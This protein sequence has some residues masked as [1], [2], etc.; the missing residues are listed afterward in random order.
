MSLQTLTRPVDVPTHRRRGSTVWL[1]AL[2]SLAVAIVIVAVPYVPWLTPAAGLWLAVVLPTCQ[3]AGKVDWRLPSA[4]DRVLVS[5]AIVLTGLMVLGLALNELLPLAGDHHPL[6]RVPVVVSVGTLSV[7]LVLWRRERTGAVLPRPLPRIGRADRYLLGAAAS[8]VLM[9]VMGANRL[10]NGAGSGLTVGM[11]VLVAV[12]VAW[13]LA[14]RGSTRPGVV[15]ATLYALSLALLLMTS[16]RGWY[17]TGHDIQREYH[18]FELTRGSDLWSM[19]RFRDPYNA[20]L[21]ITV[22]PTMIQRLVGISDPYIYKVVF[23]LLFA[24]CPVMIYR[25][26]RRFAGDL[27]ALLATVYF[28]AFPTYFT[29]MPFLDRQ[30]IAFLMIGALVLVVVDDGQALWRRRVWAAVL[31]VGMVLSHYSSTYVMCAV[32][33]CA[34][35]IQRLLPVWRRV[36]QAVRVV[37][38]GTDARPAAPVLG[39]LMVVFLVGTTFVW[40]VVVTDTAGGL[41]AT[42]VQSAD[43][44]LTGGASDSSDVKYSLFAPTPPSAEQRLRMYRQAIDR[45]RQTSPDQFYPESV[46]DRYP[47]PILAP[48]NMPLSTVGQ[49]VSDLGVDVSAVNTATRQG[50]AKLLQI[51]VLLGLVAI[52]LVSSTL[53]V[54]REYTALAWSAFLVVLLTVALPGVSANYG[55]LRAF[56]QAMFLFAPVLAYGSLIAFRPFARAWRPRLAAA[57]AVTFLLSLTGVVP[58]LLGGYPPQLNLNDSGEYYDLY[59]MHP[60][61][62]TAINWLQSGPFGS[63]PTVQSEVQTDRYTFNRLS[64]YT[65]IDE[66]NDI[67]PTLIRRGS[68]VFLGYSAT[69]SGQAT[70]SYQGDLI[71]YRYPVAFLDATKN[72]IYC[73]DGAR[74][75]R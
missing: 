1:G 36:A 27:V 52:L 58:Q 59:Y 34:W 67:Y 17:V 75:Y 54:S 45:I 40:N 6:G 28:V 3:V 68:Y 55:V 2:A 19:Q 42:L 25:I 53:R 23:Q 20:C 22:L 73:S 21:S 26:A 66:W 62:I 43:G 5:L 38:P 4:V 30:E 61:E 46:V 11:L 7:G 41:T 24:A 15:V 44:I 16:L 65:G 56:Q 72:R 60:E 37:R 74:I 14:R 18:V 57:V 35:I 70:L 48:S 50:A 31:M 9:A 49:Q 12:V 29:D 32:L 10:N 63:S 51:F 64:A 47:T 69:T 33:L 39:L 71:T 13:L 8:T